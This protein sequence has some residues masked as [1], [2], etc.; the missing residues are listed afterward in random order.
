M[1][2]DRPE[3]P[4]LTLRDRIRSEGPL[5]AAATRRL[6]DALGSAAAVAQPTLDVGARRQGARPRHAGLLEHR[7]SDEH[8]ELHGTIES[9]CDPKNGAP[10]TFIDF[11]RGEGRFARSFDAA[12]KPSEALLQAEAE[13]LANW[14]RLQELAGMR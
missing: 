11:A 1:K 13:R 3:F 12:G 6:A 8:G 5:D 9:A 4:L 10:F 2:D 14:H 7:R